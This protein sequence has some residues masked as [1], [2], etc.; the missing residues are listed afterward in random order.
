VH[1]NTSV[2]TPEDDPMWSKHVVQ[3]KINIGI[4]VALTVEYTLF[5]DKTGRRFQIR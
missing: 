5:T 1:F 2:N 4:K 3:I